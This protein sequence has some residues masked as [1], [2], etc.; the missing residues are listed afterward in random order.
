[1]VKEIISVVFVSKKNKT[2]QEHMTR[3]QIITNSGWNDFVT[4]R[5]RPLIWMYSASTIQ[6][7]CAILSM[8]ETA[9]ET[10]V[11]GLICLNSIWSIS[12]TVVHTKNK[13]PTTLAI[14]WLSKVPLKMGSISLMVAMH[15]IAMMDRRIPI[16]SITSVT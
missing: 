3:N 2:L 9:I 1:M 7:R 14:E 5:K 8:I 12:V 15:T 16:A 6:S 10:T 4:Y 13:P 11:G